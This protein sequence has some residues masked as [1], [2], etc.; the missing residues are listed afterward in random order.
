MTKNS[1][2]THLLVAGLGLIEISAKGLTIL[3][4][5][6]GFLCGAFLFIPKIPIFL[7]NYFCL[8]RGAICLP[9]VNSLALLLKTYLWAVI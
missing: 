1:G 9:L 5:L 6:D 3:Y 4:S 7:E 2:P 8:G